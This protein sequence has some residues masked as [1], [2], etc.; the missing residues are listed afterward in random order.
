MPKKKTIEELQAEQEKLENEIKSKSDKLKALKQQTAEEIRKARTHHL[1]TVGGM[2]DQYLPP[3][4][5]TEE[6]VSAI[7]K[8]LFKDPRVEQ[9][10][11]TA[12]QTQRTEPQ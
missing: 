8:S 3:D 7:L 1:C 6:Q 9:M 10:L 4:K 5:Y 2:L 11:Q 12:K